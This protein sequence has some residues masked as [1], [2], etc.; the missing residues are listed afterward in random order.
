LK[1]SEEV[2]EKIRDLQF[3]MALSPHIKMEK[4]EECLK[5]KDN[6][7]E[8]SCGVLKNDD[9]GIYIST[10]KGIKVR[11]V[12]NMQYDVMNICAS[13]L[14]IPG[15]VNMEAASLGVPVFVCYSITHPAIIPFGG[16]PGLLGNIPVIGPYLKT[17]AAYRIKKLM[18]FIS[19]ANIMADREILP[20]IN[21]DRK[22]SEVSEPVS[23][24]LLDNKKRE[25]M[26]YELKEIFK[27][28]N[29]AQNVADTILETMEKIL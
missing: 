4:L 15:T 22:A 1:V 24:F 5:Y 26:S 9:Y 27:S 6:L 12:R 7:I 10:E 23:E 2:S 14:S 19:P 29:A 21:V 25:N 13:I 11:V 20:E 28:N 16:L 8:G 18:K 17:K 3:I